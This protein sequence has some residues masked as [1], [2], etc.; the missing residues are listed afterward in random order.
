MPSI[1]NYPALRPLELTDKPRLDELFAAMQPRIS[2]LT[3]ANLYLFRTA[4]AYRLSRV[5]DGLVVIGRGYG[6]E[7]YFLPPLCGTIPAILERL[8]AAGLTLY[9]ADDDFRAR[10]LGEP[11]LEIVDDR[12]GSDYLYRRQD[13]AEL[14]GHRF[15]KKKNRINY[16]TS[17]HRHAV[18]LFGER[19][20]AGCLQL[21]DE[22]LQGHD[23]SVSASLLPEAAATREA[24]WLAGILDLEGV[25]VTVGGVAKAFVLGER[26]NHDTSVCHFEK[27]DP[28]LEGLSQ[29]IDREFNRRLFIDCT[30]VNR[31]QDL[32]EPGLREAKSAYHPLE[33]VR[34]YRVRRG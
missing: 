18:A 5:A 29:L 15:H 4:H 25:V 2:E 8:F 21:V 1:P 32:G 22:W 11:G 24:L 27:A 31:E 7:D 9:G 19:Y 13:L 34:K 10:Y 3:F 16:F 30:F 14:P 26:L 12:D 28:Q 6:G 17:R 23:E 20:L 33:L